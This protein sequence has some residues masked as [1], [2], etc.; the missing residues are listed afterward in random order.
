MS[1]KQIKITD[2]LKIKHPSLVYGDPL[3]S[4]TYAERVQT[5]TS[6]MLPTCSYNFDDVLEQ[7]TQADLLSETGQLQL[8][9]STIELKLYRNFSER[10][11]IVNTAS[12]VNGCDPT[13][14]IVQVNGS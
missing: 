2:D 12:I 5:I 10:E 13:T 11:E 9:Q 4:A 7:P 14:D 3:H 6:K 8:K 1:L